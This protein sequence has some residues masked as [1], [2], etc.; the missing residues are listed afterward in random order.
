MF[1]G[2]SLGYLN[3][4]V[5]DLAAWRSF[6]TEMLGLPAPLEHAD[7]SLGFRTDDRLQRLIVT[8]GKADDL[9]GIGLECKDDETLDRLA[10]ALAHAGYAAEPCEVAGATR[11]VRSV[12]PSGLIV[13]LVVGAARAATPFSSAAFPGGFVTGD[14]GLGHAVLAY[15]DLAAMRRYYVDTLGFGVS[16]R[17]EQRVGP[18]AIQGL[19]LHCN[20]RH[21][22]I[23]I[24]DA[25]L[26]RR[27]HHFMLQAAE[28][29]SVGRAYERAQKLGVP[30]SLTLG[31]HPDPDPTL[32]FYAATPSGFDFEIGA[33]GGTVHEA[34]TAGRVQA[35]PW[36]HKP[37][38]RL[39]WQT[40][41]ALVRY[42][43]ARRA[44]PAA[45]A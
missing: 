12:D 44:L 4:E 20:P 34:W 7:K 2:L 22:S 37:T 41:R 30:L 1:P 29:A 40:M 15:R 26:P 31:Q 43:F 5:S 21:H 13:E 38:F 39:K 9:V 45:T 8:P 36:G 27:C 18:V 32:S 10:A 11:A 6:A 35:S 14:H 17:L 28:L 16:D 33:G 19:F 3:F 25:P 42:R 24:L 23:A